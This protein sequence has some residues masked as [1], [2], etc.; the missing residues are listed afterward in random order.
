MNS[1]SINRLTFFMEQENDFSCEITRIIDKIKR[2]WN[3]AFICE[4][5]I[6]KIDK[7]IL[8]T[9][10]RMVYQLVSDLEVEK[11]F[12]GRTVAEEKRRQQVKTAEAIVETPPLTTPL[13]SK[14]NK[15][16]SPSKHADKPT[17]IVVTDPPPP[18]NATDIKEE[19]EIKK[20]APSA[21]KIAADLFSPPRTVSDIFNGNEDNSL[22][23]KIKNNRI[24]DIKA[25]IGI[26]DKFNFINDIFKGELAAYNLALENLNKMDSLDD[27]LQFIKASNLA[28]DTQENKQALA[29][30]TDILR[31]KFQS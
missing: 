14:T 27:A 31:R 3:R 28:T 17:Q 19:P 29:K 26:N 21:S 23:S 9:D 8:L 7:D 20:P 12:P 16:S 4:N 13:E 5:K 6:P 2:D 22:A 15:P 18:Q 24:T 11:L 1:Q 10:L 25:A 30:L